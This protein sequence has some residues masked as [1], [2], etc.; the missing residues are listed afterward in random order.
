MLPKLGHVLR[1][2]ALLVAPSTRV[3]EIEPLS[4]LSLESRFDGQKRGDQKAR[5]IGAYKMLQ[6]GTGASDSV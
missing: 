1:C 3:L 6:D 4:V 2:A 5:T